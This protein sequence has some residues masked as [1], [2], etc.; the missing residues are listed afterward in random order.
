MF[1][2]EYDTSKKMSIDVLFFMQEYTLKYNPS[3]VKFGENWD[4]DAAY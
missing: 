2:L 3:P 1:G 4:V